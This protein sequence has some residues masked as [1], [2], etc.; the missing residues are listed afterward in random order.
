MS[1]VREFMID[2]DRRWPGHTTN[3]LRLHIIGS[4][5]LML[6]A[7][8]VRGTKDSDVLETA[9]LDPSTRRNLVQ[10]AG[11]GTDLHR[12]H[13]M[14]MEI[15]PAGLPLLPQRP[16]WSALGEL[17][18]QLA[19]LSLE[20][21]SIVDVVISKLRRF[22]GD[23]QRDI[24][25]MVDRDLVLHC[26]FVDRFKLAVDYHLLDARAHDLPKVVANFHRVERDFFG[27]PETAIDLP[28]WL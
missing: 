23:D 1:L 28:H 26:E 27:V 22:H 16:R 15:V 19:S 13:R 18:V 8:Y 24:S 20:A 3:K 4:T 11:P 12:R 14:Y 5:A 21:L 7:D 25:A 2:L 17:N 6:Q 9:D 10:L